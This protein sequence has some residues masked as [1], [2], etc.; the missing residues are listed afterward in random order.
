VARQCELLGLPRSSFYYEPATETQENLDL[1]RWIDREYTEHPY[2]GVLGMTQRLRRATGLDYNPKRVRR[3]LRLMG[4]EAIYPKPR[5]S[6]PAQGHTVYPYLMAGLGIIRPNQAWCSDITYIPMHKGFM[7]LVA[8]VDWA[9][10]RV[11]SWRL[12]NTL[13][14]DFCLDA[15]DAALEEF[16]P[17]EVFNTDQGAQFTAAAFQ[18]RLLAR[19]VRISMDGRG[20]ALDNVFVERLWRSLKYE[21]VYL[22]CY[23]DG[24]ELFAGLR[25]YFPYYNL[26]R[27]HQGLG[28]RTPAEVY[29]ACA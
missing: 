14:V 27:P 29:D 24:Q 5:T 1:M 9:S 15:L 11:L 28:G 22:R 17:P 18:E 26:K 2:V 21:D 25:T 7:Y 19:G 23:A 16:D 12:S 20:R 10:R 4:L 13:A 3:L 6:A 8:V